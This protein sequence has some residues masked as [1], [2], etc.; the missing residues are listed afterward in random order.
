[1]FKRILVAIDYESTMASP[2]LAEAQSL[3]IAY[4]ADLHLVHVISP[5]SLGYLDPSY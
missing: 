3:A 5:V 2:V 4:Q 1:M